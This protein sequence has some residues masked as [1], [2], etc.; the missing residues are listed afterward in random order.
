MIDAQYTAILKAAGER[1]DQPGRKVYT[2]LASNETVDRDGEIL[3]RAG[4]DLANYERNPV[5]LDGHDYRSITNII[6]RA[7]GL[8]LTDDGLE[9]DVL[10]NDTPK[11]QLATQLVEA[12]DLRAVSVGARLLGKAERGPAAGDPPRLVR[13]E[14]MEIS[15]CP[16]PVNPDTLRLR[17]LGEADEAAGAAPIE[18]AG[19]ALSAKNERLLREAMTRHE[20]AVRMLGE[21]L[22]SLPEAADAMADDGDK[23]ADAAT[24]KAADGPDPDALDRLAARLAALTESMGARP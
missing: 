15:L 11:G 18:K 17:A 13:K 10:F 7:V 2:F 14:L 9:A 19:R 1:A 5:I 3:T 21:V 24:T 8:R 12:G 6:G 4:W 23:A 20:E 22:A 16:V